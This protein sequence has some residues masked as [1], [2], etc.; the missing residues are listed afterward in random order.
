[1]NKDLYLDDEEMETTGE[2]LPV[3]EEAVI[4][5]VEEFLRITKEMGC[6]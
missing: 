4:S 2:N 5:E 3:I 1:M 6:E